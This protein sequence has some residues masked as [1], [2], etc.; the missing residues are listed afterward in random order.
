MNSILYSFSYRG[1][2]AVRVLKAGFRTLPQRFRGSATFR[3]E[4]GEILN[5]AVIVPLF[6]VLL[7]R[8]IQNDLSDN[9]AQ[10]LDISSSLQ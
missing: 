10:Y 2:Y 7:Y 6:V 3:N 9:I 4:C 8:L 1:I 5:S